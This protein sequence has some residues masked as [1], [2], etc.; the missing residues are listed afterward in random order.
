MNRLELIKELI[1]HNYHLSTTNVKLLL[2]NVNKTVLVSNSAIYKSAYIKL[3]NVIIGEIYSIFN[4]FLSTYE[5]GKQDKFFDY[6]MF[7]S[8]YT[9]EQLID[10]AKIIANDKQI[11]LSETVNKL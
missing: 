5:N 8:S 2:E 6:I 4:T 9:H 3:N 11:R 1:K 10:T 7:S